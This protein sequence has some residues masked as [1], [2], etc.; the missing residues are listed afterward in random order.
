MAGR[1]GVGVFGEALGHDVGRRHRHHLPVARGDDV[2]F[3]GGLQ[4]G[5][6]E[7]RVDPMRVGR[8]ELGVEVDPPVDRVGEAVHAFTGVHVAALGD[9]LE[10][11]VVSEIAQP[12]PVG[13][14]VGRGLD[15]DPVESDRPD[16]VSHQ[17]D[18][19]RRARLAAA[20][21]D[22]RRGEKVVRLRGPGREVEE[23]DGLESGHR[24]CLAR[25]R[26][27]EARPFG[28]LVTAQVVA[29]HRSGAFLSFVRCSDLRTIGMAGA[30]C[31]R[32]AW[33]TAARAR[34]PW[35]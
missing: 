16:L 22:R 23:N 28:R 15:R 6:V 14:T 25:D 32:P 33:Q 12:D 5:L 26:A 10:F 11:V 13:V 7:A 24:F 35:F 18:K 30:K 8:L 9:D 17:V 1:R 34:L 20:E 2:E 27:D 29:W 19:R 3:E 4:V 21:T 31:T